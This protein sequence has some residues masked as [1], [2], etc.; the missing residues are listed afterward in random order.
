MTGPSERLVGVGKGQP[1]PSVWG[2]KL[3]CAAY[4][5]CALHDRTTYIDH[6]AASR[7]AAVMT[8]DAPHIFNPLIAGDHPTSLPRAISTNITANTPTPLTHPHPTRASH[9][10]PIIITQA[11]AFH[12]PP[13]LT[14]SLH[15][16]HCGSWREKA[17]LWYSLRNKQTEVAGPQSPPRVPLKHRIFTSRGELSLETPM[18]PGVAS[19]TPSALSNQWRAHPTPANGK[20]LDT[21]KRAA[22]PR[23]KAVPK[24]AH[25]PS[26]YAIRP[27]PSTLIPL[28]HSYY[29]PLN[30][31]RF[32][33]PSPQLTPS[34]P[35]PQ[36]PDIPSPTLSQSH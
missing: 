22:M 4:C 21:R 10:T 7:H 19:T 32:P 14:P 24:E 31:T 11:P 28:H 25:P 33:L 34:H 5:M 17:F 3:T 1:P 9:Q 2:G 27:H 13:F 29:N 18:Y 30:L 36:Y 16:P 6:A 35:L 15:P 26:P 12:P 23:T 8:T 20:A